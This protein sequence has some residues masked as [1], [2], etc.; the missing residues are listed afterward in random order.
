MVLLS[1]TND[2]SE[3]KVMIVLCIHLEIIVLNNLIKR[4]KT[5]YII[6]IIIWVDSL[7]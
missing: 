7:S 6:V 5:N 3:S 1:L 4:Y 2:W